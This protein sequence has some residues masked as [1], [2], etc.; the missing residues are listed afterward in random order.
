MEI[1]SCSE[2]HNGCFRSTFQP[3]PFPPGQRYTRATSPSKN[4]STSQ[5]R[6]NQKFGGKDSYMGVSKNRDTPKSSILI[7]FS[8]INHLFWGTP[9][10]GNTHM[11]SC[12]FQ[13]DLLIC[14][15]HIDI[16]INVIY[17]MIMVTFCFN[18]NS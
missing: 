7:G 1:C 13:L 12:F 16:C 3:S 15:I 8:H 5:V 14:M 4:F 9:I 6:E 10:F 17:R 2:S 11:V 18:T